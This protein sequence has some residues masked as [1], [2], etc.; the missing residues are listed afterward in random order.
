M[1]QCAWAMVRSNYAK[2]FKN[3][4]EELKIRKGS[5]RS[6]V[7]IARKMIELTYHLL[8]KGEK[9]KYMP[10]NILKRK[11]ALNNIC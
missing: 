6:I 5:G 8:R 7:A 3:K 9:Y 1:I 11:L 4:Y 2:E 10:D